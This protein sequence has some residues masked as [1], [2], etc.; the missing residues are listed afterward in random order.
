M[1]SPIRC[2]NCGKVTWAGCGQHVDEVMANV[3]VDQRCTC[4]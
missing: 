3:P 2:S 1:C 4:K